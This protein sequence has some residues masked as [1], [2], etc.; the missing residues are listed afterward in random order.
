V[1]HEAKAT[2]IWLGFA[3]A[4]KEEIKDAG[5]D[6]K[7]RTFGPTEKISKK[8]DRKKDR[9]YAII[10]SVEMKRQRE[11]NRRGGEVSRHSVRAVVDDGSR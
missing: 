6:R 1:Q 4:S 5:G 9:V 8:N 10:R 7:D 3:L 11:K 2:P